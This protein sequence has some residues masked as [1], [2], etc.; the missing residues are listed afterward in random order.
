MAKPTQVKSI[1]GTSYT[2][3]ADLE[4]QA[5]YFCCLSF[6]EYRRTFDKAEYTH[7]G[8]IFM[9]LPENIQ[10]NHR[11]LFRGGELGL[12]GNIK[13][14]VNGEYKKIANDIASQLESGFNTAK[15]AAGNFDTKNATAM[16]K[17]L[18]EGIGPVLSVIQGNGLISDTTVGSL[19]NQATGVIKNPHLTMNFE[20]VDL[21]PHSFTWTVSPRTMAD[22]QNLENIVN[23]IRQRAHPDFDPSLRS[24]ALGWP[25]EV[26]VNFIG[27]DYIMPVRRS[28]ITNIVV[29]KSNAFYEGI[30]A[31]VEY[32][33][34]LD[35]T[36]VEILTRGDLSKN[37]MTF[38]QNGDYAS[39]SLSSES[40][41]DPVVGKFG[42]N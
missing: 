38:T 9:P 20:G 16:G 11:I 39:A 34:T 24:F 1:K 37:N 2:F 4:T 31:P 12:W 6:V 18:A 14:L 22:S 17:A 40:V 36:E 26:Y 15:G 21:R 23:F 42:R 28:V 13:H 5:Q 41:A 35:M 3:P 32:R 8:N 29:N 30:G 25:D 10:E 27:T 7:T 33:I 19:L